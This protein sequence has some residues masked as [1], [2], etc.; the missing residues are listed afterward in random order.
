M[1]TNNVLADASARW[2]DEQA[3]AA[4]K[5][6]EIGGAIG[7]MLMEYQALGLVDYDHDEGGEG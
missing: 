2:I 6:V 3:V 5:W 7:A 4:R 1:E